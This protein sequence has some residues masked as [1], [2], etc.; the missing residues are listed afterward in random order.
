MCLWIMRMVEVI[1]IDGEEGKMA[2]WKMYFDFDDFY[3]FSCDELL[4]NS[5]FSED[6]FIEFTHFC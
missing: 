5:D 4:R 3:R 6:T 1:V 2:L